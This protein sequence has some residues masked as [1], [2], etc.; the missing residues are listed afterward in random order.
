MTSSFLKI[1]V[2]DIIKTLRDGHYLLQ[3]SEELLGDHPKIIVYFNKIYFHNLSYLN[4][5]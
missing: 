3:D 1:S 4:F 2:D 5:Y